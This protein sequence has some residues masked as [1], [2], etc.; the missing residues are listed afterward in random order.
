MITIEGLSVNGIAGHKSFT[1]EVI[2]PLFVQK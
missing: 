1:I 2:N